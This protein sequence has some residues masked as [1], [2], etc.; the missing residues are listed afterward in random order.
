MPSDK[1]CNSLYEVLLLAAGLQELK[2]QPF[3]RL[4]VVVGRYFALAQPGGNSLSDIME[5]GCP[6]EHPRGFAPIL[7]F[8]RLVNH[9]Q[10]VVPYVPFGVVYRGLLHTLKPFYI[11]ERESP[12]L[13]PVRRQVQEP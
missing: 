2:S 8:C 9:Y 12:H 13:R 10:R 1:R 7:T 6:H 11:D 5:Q 3:T 4:V